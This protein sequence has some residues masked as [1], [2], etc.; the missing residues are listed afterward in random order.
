MDK[1]ALEGC[2]L[3]LR[4]ATVRPPYE[5]ILAGFAVLLVFLASFSRLLLLLVFIVRSNP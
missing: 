3:F 2:S 5:S 1:D 4:L